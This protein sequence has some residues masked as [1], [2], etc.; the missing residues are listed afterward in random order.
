MNRRIAITGLGVLTPAGLGAPALADAAREGRSAVGPITRFDPADYPSKVA[1]QVPAFD[2][3]AD[4]RKDQSRYVKKNAKVM[5]LDIQL[6]VAAVNQAILSSGLPIGDFK[7]T[8]PV[9]PT[10]DHTRFGMTFG[11]NFIPTSI[12][13]MAPPVGATVSDGGAFDLKRWGKR[14]IPAMFP[15]WLLKYLPN[16]HTCHS[17]VLWDAQG[18]TNSLT[19]SDA[20]G[21]LA[22]DEGARQIE[23]GIADWMI[24]GGAES[25]VNPVYFLRLCLLGR[26]TARDGDPATLSR[27]FDAAADGM[28]AAEGATA[29]LLEPMDEA[30]ARGATVHGELLG[31]GAGCCTAGTN[32]CDADG[33]ATRLAVERALASAGVEAGDL[34]AVLAHGSGLPMQDASE[35]AGLA[36]ALGP[37]AETVPVTCLTGVTGNMGAASGLSDLAAMMA[38]AGGT[39]PPILN[40]DDPATDAP[41][42][43]VRGEPRPLASDLVL[44]STNTVGG[45]TAAAVVRLNR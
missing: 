41:L 42:N 23:R 34:G 39:V 32:A 13:D 29:F 26:V 4:I 33:T 45:Q 28:V 6:A 11:T 21:L 2:P 18:P 24:A 37:A 25:R 7:A 16:M 12:E 35:A 8:E 19:C 43:W 40:L 22:L 14:G 17:G 36:A 9:L 5:A 44:A 30:E 15:L 3:A 1:G 38:A 27:P 31:V 10:I 20:G